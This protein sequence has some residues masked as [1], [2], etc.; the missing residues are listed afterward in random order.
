MRPVLVLFLALGM[1]ACTGSH[2]PPYDRAMGPAPMMVRNEHVLDLPSLL[3]LTIDGLSQ[4]IGPRLPVPAGFLDP[5][6]VPLA[7]NN[8][9]LDSSSLFRSQGLMIL[10]SY[11]YQTREVSNLLLIGSDEDK[12]MDAANLKLGADEYLLMPVFQEKR[13][14]QKWGLRVI[15]I[16]AAPKNN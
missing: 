2:E 7:K 14:T 11:N 1:G 4:R 13:P 8:E 10:A 6:L 9:R 16:D 3:T 15:A 5:I 12:L